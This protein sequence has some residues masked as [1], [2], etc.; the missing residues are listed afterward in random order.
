ME[1]NI[2]NQLIEI[3]KRL[4]D[5]RKYKGIS[6]I[7]AAKE[8]GISKQMISKIENGGNCTLSILL[9][10]CNYLDSLLCI[11]NPDIFIRDLEILSERDNPR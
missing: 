10:Y 6:T 9:K 1:K 11:M 2:N 3:G 5:I 7:K 8:T 4:R